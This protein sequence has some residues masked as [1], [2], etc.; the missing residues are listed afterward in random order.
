MANA[1]GAAFIEGI[2]A[3]P[4]FHAIWPYWGWI[5]AAL[6]TGI[7]IFTW[8]KIY[9]WTLRMRGIEQVSAGSIMK[10]RTVTDEMSSQTLR[11]QQQAAAKKETEVA[12]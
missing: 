1:N 8:A 7:G 11:E 9:P 12:A 6:F 10:G 3:M 4:S 5:T 2:M